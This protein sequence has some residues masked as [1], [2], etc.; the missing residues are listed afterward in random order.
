[1]IERE[2]KDET[3]TKHVIKKVICDV[4]GKECQIGGGVIQ[5]GATYPCRIERQG[6]NEHGALAAIWVSDLCMDCALEVKD[7]IDLRAEAEGGRGAR[8]PDYKFGD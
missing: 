8:Q 5:H 3:L 1:M 4:C 7:F 2:K 6:F